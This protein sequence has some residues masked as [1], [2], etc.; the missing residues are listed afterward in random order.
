VYQI[1]VIANCNKNTQVDGIIF[2]A[3]KSNTTTT[4]AQTINGSSITPDLGSAIHILAAY[5]TIQNCVFS[6]NFGGFFGNIYQNNLT[7]TDTVKVSSSIFTGNFAQYGGGMFIRRGHHLSNNLV[8]FNNS[9]DYG[10]AF[11]V[12]NNM[13]ASGRVDFYNST[14]ANNYSTFG[15]SLK[16]D[17]GTVKLVNSIV[18][19]AVPYSGGNI[20]SSGGTLTSSFSILQNSSTS[21]SWNSNYGT[22][23][24]NNFDANPMF[25]N[26]SD[27]DGTDNVF[28]TTDDGLSLLNYAPGIN[29]GTN[30]GVFLTDVTLSSRPFNSGTTDIGAYE[31]QGGNPTAKYNMTL[32]TGNWDTI[33]NWTM[34]RLPQTGETAVINQS[35]FITL[36]GAGSAKDV[37]FIGT[38]KL[39]YSVNTANLNLGF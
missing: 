13:S 27:I 2:T 38:G 8:M 37:Q 34:G 10:G 19:N 17:A 14:F 25:T 36:N 32:A 3:A 35:H 9:S 26:S 12:Q 16:V 4:P 28:F 23:G 22:D 6:G 5:P 11:I 24:G 7:Y 33:T 21:G 1:L 30:T 20:A 18:Y 31:Y 39:I 29:R 15:K